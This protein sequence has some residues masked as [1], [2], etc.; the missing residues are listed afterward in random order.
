[1]S[2]PISLHAQ[3]Q[4]ILP[5][6]HPQCDPQ[7]TNWAT[8]S[9]LTPAKTRIRRSSPR[10]STKLWT[11]P[12][13]MRIKHGLPKS[14][15]ATPTPRR[16]QHQLILQRSP[17]LAPSFAGVS[18]PR[19]PE[20]QYTDTIGTKSK[21]RCLDYPRSRDGVRFLR[22]RIGT[23]AAAVKASW[24][25]VDVASRSGCSTFDSFL[26]HVK[27]GE[28]VQELTNTMFIR[29]E[30]V[31]PVFPCGVDIEVDTTSPEPPR[32][33]ETRRRWWYHPRVQ[34]GPSPQHPSEG[35]LRAAH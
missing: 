24:R 23:A 8:Q 4:S 32:R 35:V 6:P 15:I 22:K 2:S 16:R 9:G 27:R 33:N 20:I 11:R 1:V 7:R 34:E 14:E 19:R 5:T 26:F 13:P 31:S 30:G 10:Q 17:S 18:E 28:S 3:P 21:L 12:R 25:K 29:K